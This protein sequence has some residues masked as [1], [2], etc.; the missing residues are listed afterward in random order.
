MSTVIYM[1]DDATDR[2]DWDPTEYRYIQIADHI[3]KQ[4]NDGTLGEG[5]ALEAIG[6]LAE[7]YGV[8]R[9]T[10]VRAEKL[11]EERGLIVI[12]RGTGTFVK[13]PPADPR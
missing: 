4:I 2:P 9:M 3:E 8:A 1:T 12:R 6:R 10:I 5:A 11:L 13:R 7:K